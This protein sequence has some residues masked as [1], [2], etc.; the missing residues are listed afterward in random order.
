MSSF[1]C[2]KSWI[3]SCRYGHML[4]VFRV[5]CKQLGFPDAIA[6]SRTPTSQRILL[7]RKRRVRR[8][9]VMCA[10]NETRLTECRHSTPSHDL[11]TDHDQ[12]FIRCL[13]ADCS[14]YSA[15]IHRHDFTHFQTFLIFLQ[16]ALIGFSR[17][18]CMQT[19]AVWLAI[20]AAWCC[21]LSVCLSVRP[22]VRLLRSTLWLNDTSYSKSVWTSE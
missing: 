8:S 3:V 12:V 16:P 22:P 7:S 15:Y 18:Y 2:Q 14:D 17:S 20:L 11:C 19:D 6:W 5:S 9:D 1:R 10:G 13:C 4:F 21:H